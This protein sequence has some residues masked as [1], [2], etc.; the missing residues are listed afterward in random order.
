MQIFSSQVN[1]F[2][3]S[4]TIPIT[5]PAEVHVSKGEERTDHPLAASPSRHRGCWVGVVVLVVGW[6]V[7]EPWLICR[8][9]DSVDLVF[10]YGLSSWSLV[11]A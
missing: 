11:T 10:W 9:C 7:L 6:W 3:S 4:N 1:Q 2:E 5:P 8:F